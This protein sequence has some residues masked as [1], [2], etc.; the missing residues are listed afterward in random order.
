MNIIDIFNDII[1]LSPADIGVYGAAYDEE[2]RF[3]GSN[4]DIKLPASIKA[5]ILAIIVKHYEEVM[6]NEY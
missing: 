5:Q 3:T 6:N 1:I 2:G 4:F